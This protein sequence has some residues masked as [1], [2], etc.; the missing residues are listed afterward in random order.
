MRLTVILCLFFVCSEIF[1]EELIQVESGVPLIT[2]V[3]TKLPS[4]NSQDIT[5]ESEN[6]VDRHARHVR[7]ESAR[8][9]V[10]TSDSKD[11]RLHEL[12]MA[13]IDRKLS[14][15][16]YFFRISRPEDAQNFIANFRDMPDPNGLLQKAEARG[17][18]EGVVTMRRCIE[19]AHGMIAQQNA[20]AREVGMVDKAVMY[21]AGQALVTCKANLAKWQ[22]LATK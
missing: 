17:Y 20:I 12:E 22:K 6:E 8:Q 19:T 11:R 10:T 21:R 7:E 16:K 9:G 1:A 3:P 14:F 15:E 4:M 2:V 13:Q 18:R 5:L